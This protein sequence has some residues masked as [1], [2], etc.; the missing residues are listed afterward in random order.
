MQL[1]RTMRIAGITSSGVALG[2]LPAAGVAAAHDAATGDPGL[3]GRVVSVGSGDF[4]L[5]AT[6]GHTQTVETPTTTTYSELGNSAALPGVL[7]GERVAVTLDP[8]APSPT[9]LSVTVL[10]ESASGKVTDVSG[11]IV[12]VASRWGSRTLVLSPTTTY[13]EK[14]ATPSGVSDGEFVVASGLPDPTTPSAIDAQRLYIVASPTAPPNSPKPQT[15]AA[16]TTAGGKDCHRPAQPAQKPTRPAKPSVAASETQAPA[17][18]PSAIGSG[19]AAGTT[20]VHDTS[21]A[22]AARFQ[23][24]HQ[25]GP[26]GHGFGR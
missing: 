8:S 14:D 3:Q 22:G 16:R 10:P 11:S 21:D 24:N 5:R 25:R 23:G 12:T 18:R 7:D 2:L 4:V 9:A 15:T 19:P 6:Q 26:G 17:P 13:T 1:N 20:P